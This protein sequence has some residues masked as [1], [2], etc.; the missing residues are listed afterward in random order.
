MH[1]EDGIHIE[2]YGNNMITI[3]HG[4]IMMYAF[5]QESG[6]FSSVV[7]IYLNLVP[8]PLARLKYC[9]SS[10]EMCTEG[11]HMLLKH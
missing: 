7:F 1:T 8:E 11:T 2:N 4:N 5:V 3:L 10:L 9:G 6:D